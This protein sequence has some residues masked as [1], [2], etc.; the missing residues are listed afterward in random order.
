METILVPTDFSPPADNA[1]RYAAELAVYFNAEI[2]LVHAF[3][4]PVANYETAIQADVIT[5]IR[6]SAVRA[7]SELKARLLERHP[8][9][10]INTVA[11]MGMVEDVI[12][13]L[14][15]SS[16]AD[17]VVMGIIGESG[18]I[19]EHVIG[20]S[21]VK[22]ARHMRIPVFIIPEKAIY[23]KIHKV[24][25]AC[26]L[27]KTEESSLV[28]VVKYFG[29]LFDAEVDVIHISEGSPDAHKLQTSR[30]IHEKLKTIPH[31]MIFID[32]GDVS[33]AL[34]N[35]FRDFPVDL[36][37]TIPHAQSVFH[38]LFSITKKLAFH[39]ESPIM[40]LHE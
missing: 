17:A 18:M 25:F 21:S 30:Y 4:I 22:L 24:G 36:I 5:T 23:H 28:Y 10:R 39:T 2:V 13:D 37:I 40:T 19:K 38:N 31:H 16:N 8:G 34:Q 6:E 11:E 15:E 7:L 9:L 20:S 12:K 27:N 35:H 3:H 33:S 32:S 26:D 1:A 29:Q 14:A